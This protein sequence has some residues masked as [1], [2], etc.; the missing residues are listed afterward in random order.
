MQTYEEFLDGRYR[1]MLKREERAYEKMERQWKRALPLIG[2]L[3]REGKTVYY[4]NLQPYEK[5]K[6][7]ESYNQHDLVEYLVKHGYVWDK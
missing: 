7:K 2:E 5:G 6:I 4:I 3:C 1:A